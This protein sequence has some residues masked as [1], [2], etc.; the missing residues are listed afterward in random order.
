MTALTTPAP[1]C[2]AIEVQSV[3]P[4]A[5]RDATVLR[6][7]KGSVLAMLENR[8][9]PVFCAWLRS[10]R[11]SKR[12]APLTR[13]VLRGLKMGSGRGTSRYINATRSPRGVEQ[14]TNAGRCLPAG[15]AMHS[16]GPLHSKGGSVLK[17]AEGL[18]NAKEK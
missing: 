10:R 6:R 17:S 3:D 9:T 7:V 16:L 4:R 18:T 14:G 11:A 5:T 15:A 12:A 8:Q 2:R 1:P 13:L